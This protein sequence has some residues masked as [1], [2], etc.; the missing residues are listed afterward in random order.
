MG[1]TTWVAVKQENKDILLKGLNLRPSDDPVSYGRNSF[2]GCALE[3]GWYLILGDVFFDTELS[4]DAISKHSDLI[5]CLA[6][7]TAMASEISYYKKGEISFSVGHA[8]DMGQLHLSVTGNPP[9]EFHD[10]KADMLAKHKAAEMEARLEGRDIDVDYFF[11]IPLMLSESIC[12]FRPDKDPTLEGRRFQTLIPISSET[13]NG[14]SASDSEDENSGYLPKVPFRESSFYADTT[15]SGTRIHLGRDR[16]LADEQATAFGPEVLVVDDTLPLE[17]FLLEILKTDYPPYANWYVD[18]EALGVCAALM[19]EGP[20]NVLICKNGVQMAALIVMGRPV[21]MSIHNSE[22]EENQEQSSRLHH[23]VSEG[24]CGFIIDRVTGR[25]EASR[26]DDLKHRLSPNHPAQTL[27]LLSSLNKP[28]KTAPLTEKP[29][30][31]MTLSEPSWRLNVKTHIECVSAGHEFEHGQ[32]DFKVPKSMLLETFL[33]EK[34]ID[35]GGALLR[36]DYY[37][38]ASH[39][40]AVLKLQGST[41]KIICYDNTTLESLMGDGPDLTLTIS[42]N[43]VNE[44][45]L[46]RRMNQLISENVQSL[47]AVQAAWLG[48]SE[49]RYDRGTAAML[50]S[51]PH[52]QSVLNASK[53]PQGAAQS[54][55]DPE[56]SSQMGWLRTL[57]ALI[58]FIALIINIFR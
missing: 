43:D 5:I 3:S 22:A 40:C 30:E 9:P 21:E 36:S 42:I 7:D 55:P 1:T 34:I 50:A 28:V 13:E 27:L 39:L 26:F 14:S 17:D 56:P 12:D 41:Y 8:S 18:I 6:S 38:E 2:R 11:D 15:K 48:A 45:V 53:S 24:A 29:T 54:S 46:D 23:L 51:Y 32:K 52:L 47:D 19:T 44:D 49:D 33:K 4:Q 31:P 58:S 37:V 16:V 20:E 10:A 57:G 25:V 35:P